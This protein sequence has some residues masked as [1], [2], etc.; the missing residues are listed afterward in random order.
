VTPSNTEQTEPVWR[1][2]SATVHGAHGLHARPAIR[3]S[4]A[5]RG[6]AAR[7]QVRTTDDPGEE[8]Q[9]VDAKSVAKV[10]GLQV[11]SGRTILLRAV[12]ADAD[13]ALGGLRNL[14]EVALAADDEDAG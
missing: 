12:G 1:E 3:F 2:A 6:Y 7:I 5:A 9:W 8:G 11:E 10:M 4:R 13:A 14:V